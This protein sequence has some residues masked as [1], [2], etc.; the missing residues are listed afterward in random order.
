M[1]EADKNPQSNVIILK[2]IVK[3]RND[4]SLRYN[5]SSASFLNKKKKSCGLDNLDAGCICGADGLSELVWVTPFCVWHRFLFFSV[6]IFRHLND[7]ML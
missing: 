7:N 6:K 1:N 3:S 5:P 4:Q 2:P